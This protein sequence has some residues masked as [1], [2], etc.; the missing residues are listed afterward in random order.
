MFEA[1]AKTVN[2][3]SAFLPFQGSAMEKI[4]SVAEMSGWICMKV[5]H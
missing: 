4:I 5:I 3:K 2:S 1:D